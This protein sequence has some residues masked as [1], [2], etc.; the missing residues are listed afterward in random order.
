MTHDLPGHLQPMVDRAI[1]ATREL[2]EKGGEL[3][4]VA[5]I[6][7][8]MAEDKPE[9]VVIP[10]ETV[11]RAMPGV[12]GGDSKDM[13]AKMVNMAS[14]ATEARFVM[15]VSEVW[16]LAAEHAKDNDAIVKRYGSIARAPMAI[17]G[18][19]LIV[20]T[21]AGLWMALV[22][23]TKAPNG[24]RSFGEIKLTLTPGMSGRLVGLLGSA[25][26]PKN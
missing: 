3:P 20:E 13:W 18:V 9:F 6:D 19:H 21:H 24:K 26:K 14:R 8:N 7:T 15:T 25:P 12:S 1:A 11:H 10:M 17:E 23:I 2:I 16:Y 22:P 5:F 4:G